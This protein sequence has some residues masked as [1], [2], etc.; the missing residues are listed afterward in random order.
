MHK[1]PAES[2]LSLVDRPAYVLVAQ[3]HDTSVA[4][5]ESHYAAHFADASR[6][7]DPITSGAVT[8]RNVQSAL[9]GAGVEF[10]NGD[11]PGV[12]MRKSQ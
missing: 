3:L 8:V 9:E 6:G 2:P 7:A 12:R 4:M 10:T 5:I 11:Q 1:S